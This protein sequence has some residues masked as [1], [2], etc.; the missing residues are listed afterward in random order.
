M[1]KVLALIMVCCMLFSLSACDGGEKKEESKP[2][3]QTSSQPTVQ[4]E[5]K[6]ISAVV[7]F[8]DS[9]TEGMGMVDSERYP[10]VL[11]DYLENQYRVLNAGV[12]GETSFTISARANAVEFTVSQEMVFD[13]GVKEIVSHEKIFKGINKEEVRFRYSF[14]GHELSITKPIIDGKP[15]TMRYEPNGKYILC[16]DNADTKLVIPVGA[17]IKFDYSSFYDNLYCAVVL[18]GANDGGQVPVYELIN[19]Y[20]KISETADNFIAIIPFHGNDCSDAFVAEFGNKCINLRE[21]FKEAVFED[22]NIEFT[23]QDRRDIISGE[24]PVRFTYNNRHKEVHLNSLG[25][26]IMAD[27]VY[28]KGVELGYWK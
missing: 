22:Y 13:V 16:R 27:L 2:S 26:K 3:N 6:G 20:R 15:Y 7:C 10:S 19:R 17:K 23:E 12:G 1:K 9:I 28:K 11:G 25:Y 18:M 4:E 21:Y 5:N 8:G 14:M 24:I